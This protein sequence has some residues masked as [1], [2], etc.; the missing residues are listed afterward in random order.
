MRIAVTGGA[1]Y[2][3][4]HT[5]VE[6]L[7]ADHDALIIDTFANSSPVVLDRIE[8][9]TGRRPEIAEVSITDGPALQAALARFRPDAV[10]HF[11][12]LKAVGES[13]EIPLEYYRT[14]VAGSVELFRAMQGCGCNRVVFSSSAT[15][16]GLPEV[17]P[18]TEDQPCLPTNAYGQTKHMVENILQDWAAATPDLSA[19]ALRYF[20]PVGAHGSGE[21][22]EDPQGVPNNLMPYIAQVAVGRRDQLTVFGDDYDTA[23]GTGLR[24]YIHVVDL[25]RAHLAALDLSGRQTGYHAI[26][27]GSGTGHTVLEMVR[28][29]EK[30]SGQKIPYTIAPRRAGDVARS[31]ADVTLSAKL[32]NWRATHTIADMCRDTWNWQS[33]YPQGYR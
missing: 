29:F 15:V 23:D 31:V 4:S 12:G 6:L 25:A 33:R 3:G 28:A 17:L 9:L 18:V 14:N 16:Y 22:G 27:V 13:S 24:D 30:G 5:V 11:A 8:K 19:I 32:L 20:N 7:E 2:I 26:N 10:I 1:G 21:M